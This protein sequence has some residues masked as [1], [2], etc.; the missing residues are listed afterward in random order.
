MMP[1]N[2]DIDRGTGQIS[3]TKAELDAENESPLDRF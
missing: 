3:V 1:S 2:F